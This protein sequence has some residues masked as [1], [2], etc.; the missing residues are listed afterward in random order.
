MIIN[1]E[2][3]KG[4]H[5]LWKLLTNPNN[6]NKEIYDTWWTNKDNFTEKYLNWYKEIL[7]KTHSIYQNN[8]PSTK[9]AKI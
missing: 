2:R 3:Y 1:D 9:K 5:G 6:M 8:N 7:I 4:T